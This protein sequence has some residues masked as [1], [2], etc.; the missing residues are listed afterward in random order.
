MTRVLYITYDGLTDPLG[1]SQVLPYLVGCARRGHRITILSCE[2]AARVSQGQAAVQKLCEEAGLE[3]QPLRYHKRPAVASSV[4]DAWHLKSASAVLHRTRQFDLVHCRSY[5][6]AIAGLHLNDRAGLPLLFD[7]RGFWPEERTEGGS[8]DLKNPL[9]R[10]VYHYF[11]RLE[12]RLLNSSDHIVSLS[13]AGRNQ[14]LTR[15]VLAGRHADDI[16]VIPCSV[17]FD[18][19]PLARPRRAASRRALGI[20]ADAPVLAYLGSVGAWYMLDEMLDYFRVYQGRCSNA[21]F[22]FVTMEPPEAIK[23]AAKSRGVEPGRVIV[24]SATREHV[25]ELMA[26]ADA[27][28]SFIK[29]VFSKIASCPTKL[30]EMLAMGIP[31]VANAGVGDVA[32]ILVQ[33]GAGAIVRKF[34]ERSYKAAVSAIESI[35]VPPE[36]IRVRAKALF[37]LDTAVDQYSAIYD[38]LVSRRIPAPQSRGRLNK[39]VSAIKNSTDRCRL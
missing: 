23:N 34:D 16:A 35:D 24:R 29:P 10:A 27:G 2:K 6:P 26:S 5:I 19:F 12:S 21:Y 17:D 7:M 30:G 13:E 25:P 22:L 18:H 8:W 32:D 37:D 9:Y 20:E 38:S 28:I 4:Y 15:P 14:L 1:R 3:W 33:T 31:V 11:K 36:E 39:S